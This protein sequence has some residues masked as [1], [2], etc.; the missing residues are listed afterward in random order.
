MSNEVC[1][2][3]VYV[4]DVQKRFS[5]FHFFPFQRSISNSRSCS[6]TTRLFSFSWDSL[7]KHGKNREFPYPMKISSIRLADMNARTDIEQRKHSRCGQISDVSCYFSKMESI[8]KLQSMK[9]YCTSFMAL[10]FGI[11]VIQQS[12]PFVACYMS[13]LYE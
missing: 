13:S 10:Y 12:V 5:D 1:T 3:A 11:S 7:W 4:R 8:V 6:Q 2:I 9:I